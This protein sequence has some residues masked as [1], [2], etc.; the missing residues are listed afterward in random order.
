MLWFWEG[1]GTV[2]VTLWHQ[3]QTSHSQP[4]PPDHLKSRV[5]SAT[6]G[7]EKGTLR[8][9]EKVLGGQRV[10]VD[11]YPRKDGILGNPQNCLR[12]FGIIYIESATPPILLVD[13][14]FTRLKTNVFPWGIS[15]CTAYYTWKMW[16]H[17]AL[18]GTQ[19]SMA[20]SGLFAVYRFHS[21]TG[22][23]TST[24]CYVQQI[25]GD[26]ATFR[27]TFWRN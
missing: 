18:Y 21:F 24:A 11:F 1:F 8:V 13:Q 7:A 2:G 19:D 12:G 4:R 26:F 23:F 20:G 15:I 10:R 25:L 14:I 6:F 3:L 27:M 9:A 5:S 17:K 16:C 22:H